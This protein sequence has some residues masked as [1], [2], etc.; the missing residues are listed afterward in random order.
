MMQEKKNKM[1][2][3]PACEPIITGVTHGSAPLAVHKEFL[4]ELSYYSLLTTPFD[5]I[6]K[7]RKIQQNS[8]II[9]Q[10]LYHQRDI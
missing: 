6:P 5:R 7:A 2:S 3:G 4:R 10:K 8:K 1:P 9:E